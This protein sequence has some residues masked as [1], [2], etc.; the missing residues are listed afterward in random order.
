MAASGH[1]TK[2][3]KGKVGNLFKLD[4]KDIDKEI[5]KTIASQ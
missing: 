2:Q 4:N 3:K 1:N 5:A